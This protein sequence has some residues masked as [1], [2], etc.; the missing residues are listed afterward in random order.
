MIPRGAGQ[1]LAGGALV[2]WALALAA[3]GGGDPSPL[4]PNLIITGQD[5]GPARGPITFS[6]TF[7][8][9]VGNSFTSADVVISAGNKASFSKLSPGQYT[10]VV[11]PPAGTRGSLE[12][13]VAADAYSSLATRLPGA[14]AV[15]FS[16]AFD[17]Q[18]PSLAISSSATGRVAQTAFTLIFNFSEDVGS[19][20]TADDVQLLF[21]SGSGGAKGNFNRVSATQATLDVLLPAG[22]AGVVDLSVGAGAFVDLA[23]NVSTAAYFAAQQFDTR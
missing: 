23:G 21:S 9:D 19:S 17:T 15:R 2:A 13:S 12:L 8:E 3:C 10:L 1:P 14:E 5:T 11:T 16:Q 22:A 18:A 6:F 20:F 4:P 7:S